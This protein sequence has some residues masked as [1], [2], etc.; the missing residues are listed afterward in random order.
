[1]PLWILHK[2]L[3][4]WL[5]CTDE[6]ELKISIIY[7][8]IHDHTSNG[9]N[10]PTSSGSF[11]GG[12]SNLLHSRW[13]FICWSQYIAPCRISSR[14]DVK[15]IS[16]WSAPSLRL[17]LTL[18]HY[19]PYDWGNYLWTESKLWRKTNE[20]R[21]DLQTFLPMLTN[22]GNRKKRALDTKLCVVI[23]CFALCIFLYARPK[24]SS[25]SRDSC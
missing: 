8:S 14:F 20:P 19:L 9:L 12:W 15:M 23:L 25:N 13:N 18:C 5:G 24:Y 17:A 2:N 10:Y 6:P 21:I 1:M 3:F 22:C 7:K 4:V 16:C 11:I